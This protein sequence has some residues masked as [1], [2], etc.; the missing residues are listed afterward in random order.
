M[1][2][3]Y[4]WTANIDERSQTINLDIY[5]FV[6]ATRTV[7]LPGGGKATVTMRTGMPWVGQVDVDTE[8]PSGWEWKIQ[9]PK[10]DYAENY[11]VSVHAESTT[12]STIASVGATSSLQVTFDMPVRLLASHPLSFT[13]TLTVQRGPIVYTAESVDNDKVEQAYPHFAG[14]CL[15]ETAE[16]AESTLE[17]E[18]I[19]V[20]MLKTTGEVYAKNQ[21]KE[22]RSFRPI[23]KNSPAVTWSKV[24]A[25]LVLVPWFARANRGGRGHVRTSFERYTE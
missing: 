13:D 11:Q 10:P 7:E 2:G 8:A 20:V 4:T 1:L 16:F 12:G 15:S 6:A 22:A 19:P 18:G 23:S 17:I 25:G 5:L 21:V 24:D 14:V 3:G 9:L